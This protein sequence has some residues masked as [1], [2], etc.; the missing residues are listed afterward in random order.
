MKKFTYLIVL[1]LYVGSVV[2]L[3]RLVGPMIH[4]PYREIFNVLCV[5]AII[6]IPFK[7]LKPK[8]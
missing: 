3:N 2:A 7:H 8:Q 1:V 6:F 5:L 4:D